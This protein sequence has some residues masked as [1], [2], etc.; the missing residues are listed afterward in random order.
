MSEFVF[1]EVVPALFSIVLLFGAAGI[2]S[3]ILSIFYNGNGVGNIFDNI[4]FVS[5]IGLCSS[6]VL[7][8]LTMSISGLIML[9]NF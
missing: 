9:C 8:L 5:F 7:L 4:F 1:Y 2:L 3:A 6:V